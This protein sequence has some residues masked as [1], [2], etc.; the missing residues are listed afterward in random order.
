VFSDNIML[1][2]SFGAPLAFLN[3]S[4]AQRHEFGITIN[5]IVGT[6]GAA[7]DGFFRPFTG[8]AVNFSL[9]YFFIHFSS[10][11]F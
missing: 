3:L 5:A 7:I 10:P 1:P 4:E 9:V 8:S 6:A 11:H 2:D